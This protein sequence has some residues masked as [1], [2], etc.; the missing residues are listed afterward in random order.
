MWPG[1]ISDAASPFWRMFRLPLEIDQGCGLTAVA[2][3]PQF[4][5]KW[6]W[7]C[8]SWPRL[9]EVDVRRVGLQ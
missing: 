1:S 3:P 4:D 8:F 9:R 5:G 7:D 6:R 2:R